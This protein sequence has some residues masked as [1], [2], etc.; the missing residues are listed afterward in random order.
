MG[1]AMVELDERTANLRGRIL[2]VSLAVFGKEGFRNTDVQVIADRAEVGKGTV[3]RHF[4]NKEQ[5]FLATSR[6]CMERLDQ[7][8][9]EKVLATGEEPIDVVK[10]IGLFELLRRVAVAYAE[11]YQRNPLAVEIMVQERAEFRESVFPTHLSFRGERR[12][13]GELV[14]EHAVQTGEIRRVDVARTLDAYIDLLF[15]SVVCGRLGGQESELVKRV[16]LAV[17]IFLDGLARRGD[18]GE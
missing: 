16:E 8:I 3:Y 17:D 7:Y 2:D 9:E 14:L 11:F 15:G 18:A 4:G 5:L 12:S 1:A 13:R 6:H 10:R